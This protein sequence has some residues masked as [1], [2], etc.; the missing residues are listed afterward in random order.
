MTTDCLLFLH[1]DT[2]EKGEYLLISLFC[3]G[4]GN[5]C[6]DYHTIA[7][8]FVCEEKLNINHTFDSFPSLNVAIHILFSR[9]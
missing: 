8:L 5:V 7:I 9:L 4:V 2:M 3:Y 1:L 6:F